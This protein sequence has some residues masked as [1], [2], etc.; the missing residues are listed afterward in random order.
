MARSTMNRI[1]S[2][3]EEIISSFTDMIFRGV[4]HEQYTVVYQ[5]LTDLVKTFDLVRDRYALN[6]L[7]TTMRCNIMMRS[8]CLAY[9]YEGKLYSTARNVPGMSNTDPLHD[10]GLPMAV[11]DSMP[12]YTV[13]IGTG[14][15]YDKSLA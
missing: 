5:R 7:I 6:T 2:A 13:W 12:K 9:E 8:T 1:Y 4:T 11:W 10:L 14:T 15:V 3:Q